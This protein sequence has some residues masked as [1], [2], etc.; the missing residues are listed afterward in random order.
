MAVVGNPI[1]IGGSDGGGSATLGT[2]SIS[3]NGTY[4]ASSDSLDGYSEVTVN[5]PNSYAAGD[6]GKVVSNG[7]LVAQTS[8][9]VTENRTYDTTLNN[10]VV[11]NVPS[12][13]GDGAMVEPD[14]QGLAYAY[15]STGQGFHGSTTKNNYI[16]LFSVIANHKYIICLGSAHGNRYRVHF[17][18]G[19][20]ISDF[21]QYIDNASADTSS[22]YM[23]TN[24]ISGGTDLENYSERYI[25]TPNSN[26]MIIVS[27]S[28][29][30]EIVP[31]YCLDSDATPSG[32]DAIQYDVGD[33]FGDYAGTTGTSI[34]V[35]YSA[36]SGVKVVLIVLHRNDITL[37]DNSF[38][39]VNDTKNENHETQKIAIY[40]KILTTDIA[41]GSVIISKSDD[42]RL[43]ACVMYFNSDVTIGTPTQQSMDSSESQYCYKIQPSS[44]P[45]LM[46]VSNAWA[47]GANYTI[48]PMQNI[49]PHI[50]FQN[51]ALQQT[52]RLSAWVHN[53]VKPC[54]WRANINTNNDALLYNRLFI[55]PLS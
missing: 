5:V 28:N 25:F 41:S 14:Y 33:F 55:Y 12:S 34:T 36:E 37:S 53:G 19:K 6:E 3:A 50:L 38:Q 16:N 2:K 24:N 9:A 11:V 22:I 44:S 48:N 46:V 52:L 10:E 30:S 26:G 4:Q 42:S 35:N 51:V 32:G 18:S 43:C 7:S 8:L 49:I 17:Y 40:E 45:K 31:A 39:L 21:E 15:I 13:G 54:E 27:T 29:Q 47:G 1:I 23:Y 20:T